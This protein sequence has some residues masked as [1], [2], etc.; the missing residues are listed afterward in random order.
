[1]TG[2]RGQGASRGIAIASRKRPANLLG[3]AKHT[4]R[5]DYRY[6]EVPLACA[7]AIIAAVV[8]ATRRG[9]SRRREYGSPALS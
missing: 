6:S 1:M 4:I 7:G 9:S 2:A 3:G 5:S 8:E